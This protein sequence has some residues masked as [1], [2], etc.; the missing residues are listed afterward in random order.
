[1]EWI[2]IPSC[3]SFINLVL[4]HEKLQEEKWISLPG[5]GDGGTPEAVG[6]EETPVRAVVHILAR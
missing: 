2:P 3:F 4:L 6:E 1:M 5:G